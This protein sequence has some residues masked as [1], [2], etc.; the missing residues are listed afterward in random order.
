MEKDVIEA[1]EI[2]RRGCREKR[3]METVRQESRPLKKREISEE[4]EDK[5]AVNK[6]LPMD[7]RQS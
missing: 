1:G 3:S 4:E 7:R 2:K 6:S 5:M